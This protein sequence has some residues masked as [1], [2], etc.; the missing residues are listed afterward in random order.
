MIGRN[1]TITVTPATTYVHFRGGELDG[2]RYEIPVDELDNLVALEFEKKD[3][4]ARLV[5]NR[6]GESDVYEFS[7]DELAST[8]FYE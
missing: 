8:P 3:G 5:Y 7:H 4:S 6:I 2:E 1:A